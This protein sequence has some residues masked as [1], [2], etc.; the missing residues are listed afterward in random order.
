MSKPSS[1]MDIDN[2]NVANEAASETEEQKQQRVTR[3]EFQTLLGDLQTQVFQLIERGVLSEDDRFIGRALRHVWLMRRTPSRGEWLRSAT[4]WKRG[5]LA[6]RSVGAK[7][8]EAFIGALPEHP[9]AHDLQNINN[10]NVV[11]EQ[12]HPQQQVDAAAA[13]AEAAVLSTTPT[14]PPA[15]ATSPTTAAAVM[16]ASIAPLQ[17][18]LPEIDLLIMIVVT[19]ALIDLK[20]IDD[21]AQCATMMIQFVQQIQSP[22][23]QQSLQN[24]QQQATGR[25]TLNL[26]ASNAYFYFSRCYEL[27]NQLGTIRGVLL[28]G[29]RISTLRHDPHNQAMLLNLLLRNYLHDNLYDQAHKLLTK[30]PTIDFHS[31]SQLARFYYYKGRI[32]AVQLDYSEAYNCLMTAIRKAPSTGARGFRLSATKLAIIVQLLM[33]EIPERSMFAQKGIKAGLRPYFEL[34]KQV[35]IGDLAEFQNVVEQHGDVFKADKTYTLIQRIRQNVIRTGLKKISLSYSRISFADICSKLRLD[36]AEDMEYIVAKA[37]RDGIIDAVIDHDGGYM[38]SRETADVYST[39]E[40]AEGFHKRLEFVHKLHNEAV[41]AMRF[42]PELS[43]SAQKQLKE[44]DDIRKS[45]EELA[46]DIAEGGMEDDEDEDM[47]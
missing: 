40:P 32:N 21:A 4:L 22:K 43:K 24:A 41:K 30:T 2:N 37:I 23:Q 38:R 28:H 6:K 13:A 10:I 25:R 46:T 16:A 17:L 12:N 39:M 8:L 42:P 47:Y 45:E 34:T 14:T 11:N 36:H 15:S 35:R 3:E 18:Q 44:A 9:R 5:V 7:W 29:L 26:L 27:K 1:S 31:N 19:V 20:R 33:G